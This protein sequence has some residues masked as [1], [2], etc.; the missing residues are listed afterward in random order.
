[1]HGRV[2]NG[3]K[4]GDLLSLWLKS[5]ALLC[6]SKNTN[7]CLLRLIRDIPGSKTPKE[8]G[9]VF[10]KLVFLPREYCNNEDILFAG[11]WERLNDIM[12][13]LM[14][15]KYLHPPPTL[16]EGSISFS[17]FFKFYLLIFREG[18]AGRKT[19]RETSMCWLTCT[20]YWGPGPQPRHVPWLGIKQDTLWFTDPLVQFTEP[21]NQGR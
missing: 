13:Y 1:M 2:R 6:S 5:S 14:V 4:E 18:K 21:H 8:S 7:P 12:C 10:Q 9:A 11:L 15:N 3:G 17:F 19:R 16:S 20:P